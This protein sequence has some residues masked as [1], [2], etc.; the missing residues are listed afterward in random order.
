[1][2]HEY[3]MN[4]IYDNINNFCKEKLSKPVSLDKYRKIFRTLNISFKQTKSDTCKTCDSLY[5]KIKQSRLNCLL[6]TSRC[7]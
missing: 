6:Y 5:L 2:G 4:I 1:M 3:N 7:V